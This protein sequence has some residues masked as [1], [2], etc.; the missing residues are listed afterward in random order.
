M[1]EDFARLIPESQTA[2]SGK[3]FYSGRLAFERQA[4]LYIVGANPGG[5]PGSHSYQ[6]VESHTQWILT[7]HSEHNW[8]AYRDESWSG[9]SPGT[10]G[11]QPRVLHLF[12]KLGL[13]PGEVPASNL[14]FVRSTE[15]ATYPGNYDKAA[16]DCWPFHR[17]IIRRLGVRAVVC[18]GQ[19][20]G[21]SMRMRLNTNQRLDTYI[22]ENDRRW[23]SNCYVN[24]SGLQVV[25]LSHPSR[26]AW[27]NPDSDPT[28]L[29]VDALN[30]LH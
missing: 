21:N 30:R 4:N 24:R 26:A 27:T 11:M 15:M 17:A 16:N 5:D 10:A 19:D 13:D 6:T 1:I 12:R 18:L 8:S 25:T 28:H 20:A 23:E 22:E 7:Q 2:L 14:V 9:R 3:V 29:V